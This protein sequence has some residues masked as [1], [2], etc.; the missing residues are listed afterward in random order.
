MVRGSSIVHFV[1]F[2]LFSTVH[3]EASVVDVWDKLR[4]AGGGGG[5]GGG[6]RLLTS[7]GCLTIG[8]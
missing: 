2:P 8:N 7:A 1:P 6:G 4:N 5:G 3:K